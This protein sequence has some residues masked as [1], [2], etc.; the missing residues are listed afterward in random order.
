[1]SRT[2]AELAAMDPY[3]RDAI[4]EELGAAGAIAPDKLYA[5]YY[6]GSSTWSCGGGAWP[7]ALVGRVAALY[8]QGAPPGAPTCD[9]N[10]FAVPPA[11]SGYLEF[12][13]IHEIFHTLGAAAI[14]APNEV[15]AGHVSDATND[16]MWAGD[17]P[18]QFPAH[19]DIGRDDYYG[20]G[21]AG[22]VD[23]AR[24]VFLDPAG[25]DVPPGW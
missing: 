17:A 16:L 22:C 10:A 24:S 9:T 1:M 3:V 14:C 4:E 23:I 19:L 20:H 18:W 2:D 5:V 12:A 13:M 21:T 7:P 25:Q 15:L 6:D 11:G 8:L